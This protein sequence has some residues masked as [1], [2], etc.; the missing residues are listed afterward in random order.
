[1]GDFFGVHMDASYPN[2]AFP[3]GASIEKASVYAGLS[4]RPQHRIG[5]TQWI[6][7]YFMLK[8]SG[9]FLILVSNQ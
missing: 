7:A 4:G 8:I 2:A 9:Y 5:K 1:M 6:F 3:L